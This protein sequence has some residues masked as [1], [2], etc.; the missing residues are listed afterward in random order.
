VVQ[1]HDRRSA[2]YQV[3]DLWRIRRRT[4]TNSPLP[5]STP[6]AADQ[7]GDTVVNE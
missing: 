7:R 1:A 3:F 6:A 2:L 5:Q 4:L